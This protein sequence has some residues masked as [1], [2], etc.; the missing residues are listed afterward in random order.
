MIARWA[1]HEGIAAIHVVRSDASAAALRS[2]GEAHVLVLSDPGFDERLTALAH[3]M[4]VTI[5]FDAVGGELTA[6]LA[7]ALPQGGCVVVFGGLAGEDARLDIGDAI[8]RGKTVEGFWLP[9]EIKRIGMLG[10]LQRVRTVQRMGEAMFGAPVLARLPYE[11][12]GEA[13][14]L[15]PRGTEGKVLL[16]P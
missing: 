7:S 8:F 9:V 10:L 2:A 6:R 4:K 14:A 15:Q 16:V 11:R 12:I 3:Q 1:R 5:A 13:L